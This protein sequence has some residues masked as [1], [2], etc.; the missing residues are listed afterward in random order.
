MDVTLITTDANLVPVGDPIADWTN[1]DVTLRYNEPGTATVSLPRT[2]VTA[3]QVAPGSRMVMY[4][5]GKVFCAGRIEVPGV[6][7]WSV[8]GPNSEPGTTQITWSDDLAWL[9]ARRTYPTP[10]VPVTAQT[11]AR[12]TATGNAEDILRAL[13]NLNAGPSA[14]AARRLPRLVLG[15]D[16]GVGTNVTF[17]TRFESLGDALRSV[18]LAGG[19]GFRTT[20]VPGRLIEFQVYRPRDLRG[21]VRFSQGLSN[22]RSYRYEPQAPTAT[23]AI[24]GGQDEGVDRVIVERVNTAAVA[25]WGRLET[26]V[27][28]RQSDDTVGNTAELQQAGDEALAEGAETARLSAVTIDIPE[29]RFGVD[30][31][32]GD[33]VSIELASG[34]EVADI[35]RGAH[36][37]ATPKTGEY[38]TALVGSQSASADPLWVAYLRDLSRRMDRLEVR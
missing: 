9:V 15:P 8:E 10:A 34:I 25:L 35:V 21:V 22:L 23:V 17:G 28:R 7:E 32:L 3:D 4:R 38:V 30:Y 31:G 12:W 19:L 20:Q 37:Q 6:E 1:L 33:I 36:Y 26:F 24:V 16:M 18:A 2:A 29:Q 5:D 27:D 14:L 11:D 13:V